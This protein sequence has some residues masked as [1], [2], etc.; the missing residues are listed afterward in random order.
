MIIRNAVNLLSKIS[1]I[2][3]ILAE[4]KSKTKK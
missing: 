2:E 1:E 3:K 4:I